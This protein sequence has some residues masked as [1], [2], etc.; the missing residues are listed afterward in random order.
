MLKRFGQVPSGKRLEKIQNSKNYENGAFQNVL[1]TE[2][3]PKDVSMPTM[4][5]KFMN[6]PANTKPDQEIPNIKTD[7]SKLDKGKNKM[8]WF[9]HSSYFLQVNGLTI[10]VDPVFSGFASPVRFFGKA[11]DG[12]DHY[13]VEDMPEIDL[14]ILTHDHYDH[15]DYRTLL[16]LCPKVKKVIASLGVGS[17][18]EKWGYSTSKITELNWWET[19]EFDQYLQIIATPSRHFSGRGL[20][21]FKTL[22][23]SFILKFH[24]LQ[25][26]IGGDSGY[27]NTFQDLGKRYGPFDL[28]ILE[29]GQYNED[30]PNIHMMPEETVLAA[31]DLKAKIAIPVHHSKFVLAF[32][33][34]NEPL[35][36]F[37]SEARKKG[38]P[39]AAPRIGEIYKIGEPFDQEIWW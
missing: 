20:T 29:C 16:E 13:K 28:A 4:I 10:L 19:H 32:H 27:S 37:V 18:L 21:R 26:F 36:R 34:W 14:L 30:W 9:G 7:L 8:I 1:P 22:W 6:R 31:K 5:W 23:S 35:Q 38:Q 12:A 17:H 25:I 15:L 39:F 2:V 3:T 33:P 11:F 24:N